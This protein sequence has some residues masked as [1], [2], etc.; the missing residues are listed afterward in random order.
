MAACSIS[1]C[2][3]MLLFSIST[4][5]TCQ[6]KRRDL[7]LEKKSDLALMLQDTVLSSYV[8]IASGLSCLLLL[9]SVP[10]FNSFACNQ[11]FSYGRKEMSCVLFTELY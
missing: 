11:L 5:I 7:L 3:A 2:D 4:C 10:N 9:C 6:R 8:F 1:V